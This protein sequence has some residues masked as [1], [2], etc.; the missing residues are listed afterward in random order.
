MP[1][2]IK[3]LLHSHWINMRSL[4]IRAYTVFVTLRGVTVHECS[5]AQLKKFDW[6][7]RKLGCC[8]EYV[9]GWRGPWARWS[10]PWRLLLGPW[11][12]WSRWS[13][14]PQAQSSPGTHRET[15][16]SKCDSETNL[17]SRNNARKH[18]SVFWTASRTD[19]EISRKRFR[20][21]NLMSKI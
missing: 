10:T 21:P 11:T 14:G 7:Q 17:K 8:F 20:V 6:E 4:Y 5:A 18:Y 9:P 13:K 2:K 16:A 15:E 19:H 1:K 3:Y 12:W